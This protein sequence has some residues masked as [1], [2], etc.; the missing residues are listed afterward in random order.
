MNNKEE[1]KRGDESRGRKRVRQPARR[2]TSGPA[3]RKMLGE[4]GKKY[5]YD[6]HYDGK[7]AE[8]GVQTHPST[9]DVQV[10]IESGTKDT[11]CQTDFNSR[12]Y[13]ERSDKMARNPK[14]KPLHMRDSEDEDDE[15]DEV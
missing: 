10:Q 2:S 13:V 12:F 3:P 9:S 7:I 14:W 11:A 4:K 8:K 6:L 1:N 5:F 15:E